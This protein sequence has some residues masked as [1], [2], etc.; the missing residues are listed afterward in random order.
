MFNRKDKVQK[1]LQQLC[2]LSIQWDGY[3][4]DKGQPMKTLDTKEYLLKKN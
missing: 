3:S 4:S 1:L 2:G